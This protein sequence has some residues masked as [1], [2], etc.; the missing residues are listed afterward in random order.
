MKLT[1]IL[2]VLAVAGVAVLAWRMTRGGADTVSGTTAQSQSQAAGAQPSTANLG[3]V[4]GEQPAPAAPVARS[5]AQLPPEAA[6]PLSLTPE[7][8]SQ[9]GVALLPESGA[10]SAAPVQLDFSSKYGGMDAAGRRSAYESLERRIS[11]SKGLSEKEGGFS[12][13]GFERAMG[14]LMWLQDNLQP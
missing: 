5:S 1:H 2:L 13:E 12:E 11:M 4:P 10:A 3:N 14:E 6:Q 9:Q 8:S 7:R